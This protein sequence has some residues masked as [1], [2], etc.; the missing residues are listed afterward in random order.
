MTQTQANQNLFWDLQC[1]KQEEI[2]ALFA[3]SSLGWGDV[4]LESTV[5]VSFATWE[6]FLQQRSGTKKDRWWGDGDNH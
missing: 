5:V 1:R 2:E 6:T 3:L 4:I